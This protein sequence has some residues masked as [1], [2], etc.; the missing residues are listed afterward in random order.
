MDSAS[1]SAP[2]TTSARP[3]AAFGS[4]LVALG[5][6]DLDRLHRMVDGLQERVA[7][8]VGSVR[9]PPAALA[10]QGAAIRERIRDH[11]GRLEAALQD[12][13]PD[14]DERA[15]VD[16]LL[17]GLGEIRLR[18][19]SLGTALR[20]VEAEGAPRE[21]EIPAYDLESAWAELE[22]LTGYPLPTA[23]HLPNRFPLVPLVTRPD[24]HP[25]RSGPSRW[26]SRRRRTRRSARWAT[27]GRRW[28]GSRCRSGLPRSTRAP[29]ARLSRRSGREYYA[30]RI[31]RLASKTWTG[32][33]RSPSIPLL[34]NS[35]TRTSEWR[36]A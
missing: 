5:D 9:V 30:T 14:P 3:A 25:A 22:A 17:A 28:T 1:H 13:P 18:L 8:V 11:T 35:G 21:D 10:A 15:G 2:R 24:L 12:A 31:V 32:E 27:S 36:T 7:A 23:R 29:E 26:S 16:E 33:R 19:A 20:D 4:Y 6:I 34:V